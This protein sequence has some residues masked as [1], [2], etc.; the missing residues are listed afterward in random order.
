MGKRLHLVFNGATR[1]LRSSAPRMPPTRTP[2]N[3]FVVLVVEDAPDQAALIQAA[4][5]YRSFPCVVHVTGSSEEAMDYLLG[6]WPFDQRAR[7]PYPNV[8]I[9]D[10]SLPGMGGL[11]F[12]RWLNARREPWSMTPVVVFTSNAD[13]TVATQALFLGAREF[14]VKPV[15]F[16]G[17]VDVVEGVVQRWRAGAA[18]PGST[19]AAPGPSSLNS[20][21]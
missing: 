8:L 9:L 1:A 2:G 11:D 7:H 18:G 5:A 6:R 3:D 12:L 10:L 17:L 13:P 20:G 15:D 19:R 14:M 4:F 21:D 16:T